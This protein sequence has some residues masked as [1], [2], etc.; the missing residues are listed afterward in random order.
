MVI[1]SNSASVTGK[2]YYYYTW[3][4]QKDGTLSLSFTST[5]WAYEIL[6]LTAGDEL[7]QSSKNTDE[8]PN[9]YPKIQVFKGDQLL[10]AVNRSSATAGTVKFKASFSETLLGTE[11]DPFIVNPESTVYIRV[12]AGKS[13]YFSSRAYSTTLTVG[14]ASTANLVFEGKTYKPSKGKIEFVVRNAADSSE[15]GQHLLFELVNNS[16]SVQIYS[17][18]IVRPSGTW[19]KPANLTDAN[20]SVSIAEGSTGYV[21]EWTA[22]S[23][24]TLTLTMQGDNWS[25]N[26]DCYN[27]SNFV[28]TA[29]VMGSSGAAAEEDRNPTPSIEYAAG[30]VI[31]I[32]INTADGKAGTVEFT[33]T[34]E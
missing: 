19:D 3:T 16:S 13:V 17:V 21:Y 25:Y 34:F 10:I 32:T 26:M 11:T 5:V 12:P 27:A 9:K 31:R 29:S 6:N 23:A 18:T 4:A 1:G 30:Q 7:N 2:D 20:N 24:G 28:V 15:S 22:T 14:N 8:I 33:A